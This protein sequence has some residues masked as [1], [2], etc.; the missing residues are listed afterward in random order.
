MRKLFYNTVKLSP[1][2][3]LEKYTSAS[4][5]E[6][7]IMY[8]FSQNPDQSFTPF[9]VQ[10]KMGTNKLINSVRR[11]ITN[12]CDDGYLIKN[13]INHMKMG[14]HGTK[15]HTWKFNKNIMTGQQSKL[16]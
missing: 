11:S 4:S 1:E 6:V 15:N 5:L 13:D 10:E 3:L 7:A 8:F 2:E 14:N 9:E 12:L 16:F